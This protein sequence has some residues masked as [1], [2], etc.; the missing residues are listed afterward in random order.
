MFS[1]NISRTQIQRILDK[2]RDVLSIYEHEDSALDGY[3]RQTVPV[4]TPPDCH[5]R[6]NKNNNQENNSGGGGGSSKPGLEAC[7]E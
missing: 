6:K 3:F 2:F 5:L 4:P 7:E 1:E